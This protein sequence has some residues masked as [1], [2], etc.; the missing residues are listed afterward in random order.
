MHRLKP[1]AASL[2]FTMIFPAVEC[3]VAADSDSTPVAVTKLSTN[4]ARLE[5]PGAESEL[6]DVDEV[7]RLFTLYMD[8]RASGTTEEADVIAKQIVEVS[9]RDYGRDSKG[10]ARA[11][12]NLANL[13]ITNE[14]NVAAIQ[15][16]TA[17]IEIIETVE[18]NLSLDLVGPLSAM[19]SAQQQSGNIDLAQ[20]AWKRAV[21]VTHVNLGPHNYQQI[22]NLYLLAQ[23]LARE[24][25]SKAANKVRKHIQ[26]LRARQM[27]QPHDKILLSECD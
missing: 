25:E 3:A 24:G 6:D 10:T 22:E 18:D 8:A 21:H 17:A 5:L 26:Y 15:N 12:T 19:G 1:I 4:N 7:S 20:I 14:E 13:Q 9:I 27:E 16:L 2:I 23:S 11:L